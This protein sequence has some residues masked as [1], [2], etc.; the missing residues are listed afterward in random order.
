M[1]NRKIMKN[2]VFAAAMLCGSVF[3][4][5][6]G[7]VFNAGVWRGETAYVDIP[8]W[9][10]LE[11]RPYDATTEGDVSI[12]LAHYAEVSYQESPGSSQMRRCRD[13]LSACETSGGVPSVAIVTVPA[14]AKPGKRSF[15]PL[16]V[17]VK[18]NVL[19]QPSEWKYFLDL[20]QH[21]WA[22]ARFRGV[23][24][25]SKEHYAAMRPVWEAIAGCGV[26]ALTTTLL[27][28][29]WNH[30][31]YD[32]YASMIGRVKND[33]GSWTFD[34]SIFDEYVEFGRSCGI[35]PD[36]ACYTMCPW[37]Y[38]VRW[39]DSKGAVCKVAA[40]PGSKEFA[41]YWGAFLVDFAAHLKA[42]GWFGDTYI[43]MDERSPEDVAAIAKF[44]QEKAPGMKIAMAGNRKPSDFKGIDIDNYC[45]SIGHVTKEFLAEVPARR[46][47]G[48]KTTFY[49][50]CGPRHPNTFMDSPCQ[51]A[52]WL[53]VYPAL[54]GLD[55]FLRW[56]V[57]S[58]PA[59]PY[60]DASFGGWLA[61]DT[62][63]VYP[64]GELSG[65]LVRLRNGIVCAE[66]LR[67]LNADG[68]LDGKIAQLLA[69][70]PLDK[71][72]KGQIDYKAFCRDL[73]KLVK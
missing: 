14:D 2:V 46:E 21:P 61:G 60:E 48:M 33:D 65:R 9:A 56:A 53:G 5:Y 69:K 71:A 10:A 55:G 67:I 24:P 31:C 20:W 51:E 37:G 70:Y 58:W 59:D 54:C 25:F 45:Q 3:A 12:R 22:V 1:E 32:G 36:I 27:D 6:E 49:V 15:G 41:D 23:E 63:L 16:V 11:M 39:R 26:K 29:P 40:K 4:A 13:V 44:I 64:N 43:A 7:P 73:G 18:N 50:C 47:K 52:L 19:P 68:S 28:L 66:K 62:F 17:D 57:N 42:K 8:G 30:Q 72:L 34:Y 35:G 38:V